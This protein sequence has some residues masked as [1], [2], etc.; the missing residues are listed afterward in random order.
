M[1]N[2][3][4]LTHS[5]ETLQR[6][7]QA[8]ASSVQRNPDEIQLVA[9]TKGQS[10][11]KISAAVALGQTSFG[12][13]YLQEALPKITHFESIFPRL[14]WHF[15]GSLQRNKIKSI[16]R[17]FSWVHSLD[18]IEFAEKLACC[19]PEH[20]PFLNVCIQVNLAGEKTKSGVP[21]ERIRELATHILA[22]KGNLRLRGLMAIP[23]PNVSDEKKLDSFRKLGQ[24][25][26]SLQKEG[27]PVDTLSMGMSEDL[28][29][30][31][32]AGATLIRVG[33][34]LFGKRNTNRW[35]KEEVKNT[36][37]KQ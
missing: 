17:Y 31:I 15:I 37:V 2:Y 10:V 8:A 24:C 5:F 12:E 25:F 21:V 18:R 29:L 23:E 6:R 9:V 36:D 30:A 3:P 1:S 32:Q 28:E 20:L 19:R 14:E 22:L 4:D 7:I 13:N 16:A 35:F 34:A 33:T 27:Y 11:E 26:T